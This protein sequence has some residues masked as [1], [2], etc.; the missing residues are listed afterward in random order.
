MAQ[1]RA[2]LMAGPLEPYVGGFRAELET[3]G[4]SRWAVKLRV[5]LLVSLSSWL[6]GQGLTSG[7]LT[8]GRVE[9]F[10]EERRVR[11]YKSW[12]SMRSMV[13]PVEYLRSVAAVPLPASRIAEDPVEELVTTYHRYLAEERGWQRAPSSN[14]SAS[15][16]CSLRTNWTS[17]PSSSAA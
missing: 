16:A 17:V 10:V 7:E 13:L 8:P 14:M 12:I 11:G 2:K 3:R 6:A 9:Q 15:A 5:W 1:P 4:Y